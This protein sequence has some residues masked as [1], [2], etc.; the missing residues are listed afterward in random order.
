MAKKPKPSGS[1]VR[2][3]AMAPSVKK[4]SKAERMHTRAVRASHGKKG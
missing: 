1:K 2:L 4:D 3:A